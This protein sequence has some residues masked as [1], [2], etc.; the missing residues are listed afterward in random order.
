MG[1]AVRQLLVSGRRGWITVSLS[2]CLLMVVAATS[3]ADVVEPK[4]DAGPAPAAEDNFD[5]RWVTASSE[6]F[7]LYASGGA[8]VARRALEE[9]E[10]AVQSLRVALT[11][12][13]DFP[14]DRRPLTLILL[15]SSD[16]YWSVAGTRTGGA[17]TSTRRSRSWGSPSA[18]ARPAARTG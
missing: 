3:A 17:R 9:A 12:N 2:S 6:H 8:R 1:V 14:D 18:P 7:V 5:D 13:G 16:F 4:P 15:A 11:I 10:Q